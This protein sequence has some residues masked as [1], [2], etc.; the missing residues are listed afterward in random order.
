MDFRGLAKKVDLIL[1]GI[2]RLEKAVGIKEGL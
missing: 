2:A 1:G